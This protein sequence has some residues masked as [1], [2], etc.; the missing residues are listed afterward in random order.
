MFQ[1]DN[2]LVSEEIVT[3][4]FVC[5]LSA[6]KGSCCVE[7]ES[8]AP[9]EQDETEY[10]EKNYNAIAPFLSEKGRASIEKQGKFIS[11]GKGEFETPLVENKECAYV[12]FGF[13]G[14]TQ[15]GIEN[16]FRAKKIDLKKPISCHLYPVRVKEYSEFKSVNYHRWHICSSACELGGSLKI[17][18]YQ[19]VKDALIRKF[20]K[21]WYT[22]LELAAQEMNP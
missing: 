15:C 3:S 2:T 19:F 20:G 14:V 17:P 21:K 9:L 6:C 22:E 10:L 11:L 13:N 5:N 8:G 4:D 12:L 1:I 18:I 7:G 16:A